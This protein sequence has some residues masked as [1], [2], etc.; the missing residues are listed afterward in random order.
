MR[1]RFVRITWM[2][3]PIRCGPGIV[4]VLAIIDEGIVKAL[5]LNPPLA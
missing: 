5:G 4:K 2:L 1:S 3:R